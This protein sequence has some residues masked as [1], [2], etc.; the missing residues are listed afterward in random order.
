MGEHDQVIDGLR[1]AVAGLDRRLVTFEARVD[2]RFES[3]DRRFERIDVRLDALNTKM[4]SHFMWLVGI[5]I[6]ILLA[7]LSAR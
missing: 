3:V 5:Q 1:D 4:S 7:V 6:T 2:R